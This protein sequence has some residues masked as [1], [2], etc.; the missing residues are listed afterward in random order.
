MEQIPESG[1]LEFSSRH[2]ASAADEDRSPSPP[3]APNAL[4]IISWNPAE[5]ESI[6]FDQLVFSLDIFSLDIEFTKNRTYHAVA[7]LFFLHPELPLKYPDLKD[8]LH[9]GWMATFKHPM[10]FE[11]LRRPP[12]VG[13]GTY[14]EEEQAWCM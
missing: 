3:R 4:D 13:D 8:A 5:L 12:C 2:F 7:I 1:I 6:P 11:E 14:T 10:N 9:A